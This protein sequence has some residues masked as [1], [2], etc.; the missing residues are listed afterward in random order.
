MRPEALLLDFDGVLVDTERLHSEALY[1]AA[2]AMGGSPSPGEAEL[3]GGSLIIMCRE[4]ITNHGLPCTPEELVSKKAQE[5]R[6]LVSQ[7]GCRLLS[8]VAGFLDY[9]RSHGW[10]LAIVTNANWK[11]DLQ[12]VLEGLPP[13]ERGLLRFEC[14]I[15]G[16]MVARRKP[17]PDCYV[18]A[19]KHLEVQAAR[20]L[21]FEDSAPGLQAAHAAGCY[22]VGVGRTI[23]APA[24]AWV[25]TLRAA[26]EQE[27]WVDA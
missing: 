13:T 26:I 21:A 27:P 24:H 11:Y 25:H 3:V 7:R 2:V 4:M 17:H 22:V 8:G 10:R 6:S 9:A 23:Q 19:I 5:F 18:A 14:I 20:C 15:T 12:P 16:D 1:R